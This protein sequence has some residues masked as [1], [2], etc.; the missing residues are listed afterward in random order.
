[1]RHDHNETEVEYHEPKQIKKKV[2]QPWYKKEW[3][4]DH[5]LKN[6][7]LYFSI[8]PVDPSCYSTKNFHLK[9]MY[10]AVWSTS[11]VP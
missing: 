2:K 11:N 6:D 5:Y 9:Q 8:L 4:Q 3:N 1:M 10:F 7:T